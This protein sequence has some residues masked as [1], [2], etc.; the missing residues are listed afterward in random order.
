[1][2]KRLRDQPSWVVWKD[3]RKPFSPRAGGFKSWNSNPGTYEEAE[4]FCREYE[5]WKLGFLFQPDDGFVGLDLDGCRNPETGELS[6][7]AEAVLERTGRSFAEV[8]G[9]G[10]GIKIIVQAAG[11][12]K[13]PKRRKYDAEGEGWGAHKPHLAIFH[14]SQYFALT[15]QYV[16]GRDEVEEVDLRD[17]VAWLKYESVIGDLFQEPKDLREE[18]SGSGSGSG[19]IRPWVEDFNSKYSV[20]EIL[21]RNGW[22]AIG[23]SAFKR[24]GKTDEGQS[25][26]INQETGRLTVWTSESEPFQTSL[27]GEPAT[28]YDAWLCYVLLE[29][30]GDFRAARRSLGPVTA[31]SFEVSD[32]EDFF[33]GSGVEKVG[34]LP[35]PGLELV[36]SATV[37]PIALAWE[38]QKA[39]LR[40][41]IVDGVC[42]EGETVNLIASPKIGKS[43]IATLLAYSVAL[44]LK[45]LGRF[46]TSQ[47]SV[48]IIDN[49]LHEETLLYR[50]KEIGESAFGSRAKGAQID[51]HCLRGKNVDIHKLGLIMEMIPMGRYKLIVLDALYRFLP[52]GTSEN[53]NAQ[54]MAIYNQL[55]RFADKT[56]SSVVVVHHSSKGNQSEKSVTDIGSGAGSMARASD[57]H[58]VIRPHKEEGLSVLQGEARSFERIEPMSLK[59]RGLVWEFDRAAPEVFSGGSRVDPISEAADQEKLREWLRGKDYQSRNAMED[60]GLGARKVKRVVAHLMEAGELEIDDSGRYETFRL[61][62]PENA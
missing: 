47:G 5:G 23:N 62:E 28:T 34:G 31:D 1:M 35:D 57:T 32:F 39:E 21:T 3:K 12:E 37:K 17:L 40:P 49:E 11:E 38:D 48:L 54:M 8:S 7:W 2:K 42:R 52:E 43:L 56:G 6:A 13:A 14:S 46:D 10:T 61:K 15:G 45:W 4:K 51:Y 59:R 50:F 27:P 22:E 9:S 30:E 36:K 20:A 18:Y 55:D 41:I 53:D 26:T 58:I 19:E 33:S 29:H 16:H 44:G 25:A 60:S 24:P